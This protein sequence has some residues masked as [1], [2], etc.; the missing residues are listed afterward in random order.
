MGLIITDFNSNKLR[1]LNTKVMLMV[2]VYERFAQRRQARSGASIHHVTLTVAHA[3][4]RTE[5]RSTGLDPL[6]IKALPTVHLEEKRTSPT[7]K[8]R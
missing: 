6:L 2:Y 8:R 3:H 7:T 1:Q 5:P 4:N